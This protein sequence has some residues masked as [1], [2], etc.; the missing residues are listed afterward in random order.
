M[1]ARPTQLL[2][3]GQWWSI[4]STQRPQSEQWCARGGL[5]ASHLWQCRAASST[6]T[7]LAPRGT[8]PGLVSMARAWHASASAHAAEKPALCSAPATPPPSQGAITRL[9]T[10]SQEAI[11]STQTM[12][13]HSRPP[14]S[15]LNHSACSSRVP[16]PRLRLAGAA[17]ALAPA[18]GE[19]D[20]RRGR[21]GHTDIMYAGTGGA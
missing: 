18:S 9:S 16:Q 7:G 20:M 10:P 15:A 4:F 21:R 6:Q 8:A 14:G 12:P 11:I 1:F 13:A 3:Q 19:E 2:I 5:K 17:A